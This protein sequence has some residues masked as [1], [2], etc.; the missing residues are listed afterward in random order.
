M[1]QSPFC[2]CT[3]LPWPQR[4]IIADSLV[5]LII[6]LYGH[7]VYNPNNSLLLETVILCPGFPESTPINKEIMDYLHNEHK[8]NCVYPQYL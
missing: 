1:Y 6:G 2:V 3:G 4:C 7:G 5:C 8:V